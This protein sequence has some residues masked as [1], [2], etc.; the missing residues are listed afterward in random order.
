MPG[1]KF[2]VIVAGL[3]LF[4]LIVQPVQ[5]LPVSSAATFPAGFTDVTL[6]NVGSPTALAFTP[7]GRLLITT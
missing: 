7:D 2:R 3:I 1:S 4:G 5:T 6:F